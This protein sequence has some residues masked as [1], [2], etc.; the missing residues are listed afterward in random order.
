M[1]YLLTFTCYGAH[2][3][4]DAFDSVDRHHDIPGS[5][6]AESS[7]DRLSVVR[8]QMDQA[9]YLLDGDRRKMV[10]YTLREVC[11]YRGWNLW[12]AHVRTNHVHVVVEAEDR[13]EKVLQ[14]FKSYASRKL[15]QEGFDEPERKRWARHESTRW[16]WKDEDFEKAIEYVVSKQGKPMAVY[17]TSRM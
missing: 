11:S 9:S 4:G 3:H 10:L 5:R 12:A 16:L 1:R 13:P 17:V 2:L 14:T 7:P 6:L 8:E 15:N